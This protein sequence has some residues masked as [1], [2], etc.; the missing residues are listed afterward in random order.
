MFYGMIHIPALPSLQGFQSLGAMVCMFAGY[1][2]GT[3][4]Q[5]PAGTALQNNKGAGK[6]TL[7]WLTA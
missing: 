5:Y 3:A 7:N 4:L 6:A 1:P 2:A